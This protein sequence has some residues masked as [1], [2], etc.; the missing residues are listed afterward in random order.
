[1]DTDQKAQAPTLSADRASADP[2]AGRLGYAPFAKR[3][4]ES[5]LQLSGAEG[6]V[7]A[8]YGPWGC[9]KT[10]MLNYVR[11]YVGEGTATE[12]LIVV[13]FN[14]WWF[15]E[16]E[17]LIR[18][19]F[20]QLGARLKGHKE[21]S[22][23]IRGKLADFAE[24]VSEVPLPQTG[25]AKTASRALRPKMKDIAKL[26]GELS[27]A[28]DKQGQRILVVIDD[29]DRLTSE[30]IRQVFRVVKAVADFPKVTY[31][32]AFDKRVVASSLQELQGGSGEDYLEK[33]VQVPFELPLV[34]RTSI[35]SF[36]SKGSIQFLLA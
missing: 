20:S 1:M 13:P 34:D 5:I 12:N 26:K 14:P 18:A 17:D 32:M 23:K 9:G 16:G 19:F 10:T 4:A 7:I 21:F 29:I 24:L 2:K 15:A 35:R 30:E 27:N 31:L 6:H 33:I 36:F 3:L 22:S 8:L 11:H 28:L 25:W